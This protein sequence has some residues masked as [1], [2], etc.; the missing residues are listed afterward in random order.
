M[1]EVRI[2]IA[3]GETVT[4]A[5]ALELSGLAGSYVDARDSVGRGEVSVDGV[6]IM[7]ANRR[8][9]LDRVYALKLGGKCVAFAPVRR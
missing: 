2:S 4:V 1:S 6:G 3:P 8:L 5:R 7:H 9:E